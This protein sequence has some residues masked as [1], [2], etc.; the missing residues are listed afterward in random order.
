V[1]SSLRSLC[2]TTIEILTK[3]V[4]NLTKIQYNDSEGNVCPYILATSKRAKRLSGLTQI[5]F[6]VNYA[7]ERME[8]AIEQTDIELEYVLWLTAITFYGRCFASAKGRRVKL[9]QKHIEMFNP[10]AVNYH[11]SLV[12]LRNEYIAHAG[13]SAYED[14][15]VM[16]VLNPEPKPREIINIGHNVVR[17]NRMPKEEMLKF[18]NHCEELSKHLWS[19]T[20][21]LA[22]IVVNEYKEMDID[23]LYKQI[24][25]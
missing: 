12:E 9:E 5:N 14:A 20:N 13:V 1:C 19:I 17:T 4:G 7:K 15:G 10:N 18:V 8:S 25:T 6:D 11:R 3:A 2:R 21:D 16:I 22:K 24:Q 23:S